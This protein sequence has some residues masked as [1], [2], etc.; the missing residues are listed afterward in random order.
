MFLS[1][2]L[3]RRRKRAGGLQLF[4][5]YYRKKTRGVCI[6][7]LKYTSDENEQAG[8]PRSGDRDPQFLD[9]GGGG[10]GGG[11]RVTTY[12]PITVL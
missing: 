3:H 1:T 7:C 5:V 12:L 2:A 6:F 9:Y 10:G 11:G 8:D 4:L